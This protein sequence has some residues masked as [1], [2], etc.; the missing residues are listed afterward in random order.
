MRANLATRLRMVRHTGC[1]MQAFDSLPAPLRRWLA[2]AALPWSAQ[3]ALRIWR[4]AG[5]GAAALDRLTRAETAML[6]RDRPY[7]PRRW[8]A[9]TAP[10]TSTRPIPAAR[11]TISESRLSSTPANPPMITSPMTANR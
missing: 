2:Q 4:R 3:S 8:R 11:P 5:G 10:Q 9:N 7:P 6:A 1:P